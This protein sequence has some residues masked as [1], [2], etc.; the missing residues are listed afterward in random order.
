MG[1]GGAW[2]G[3]KPTLLLISLMSLGSQKTWLIS[4]FC[5]LVKWKWYLA[6]SWG[7]C[8]NYMNTK[9]LAYS[10][11]PKVWLS[12]PFFSTLCAWIENNVNSAFFFFWG[13][14]ASVGHAPM[15][16]LCAGYPQQWGR[17]IT[18][19]GMSQSSREEEE[20]WWLLVTALSCNHSITP[21]YVL[22]YCTWKGQGHLDI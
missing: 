15:L 3:F 17:K 9:D 22:F 16:A 13:L 10:S 20:T 19:W 18:W 8:D 5:S 12:F 7:C 1:W 2:A 11:F 21:F 14:I 4:K 6:T